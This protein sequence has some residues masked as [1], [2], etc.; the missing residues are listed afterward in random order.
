ML[1]IMAEFQKC[2]DVNFGLNYGQEDR[3]FI[4]AQVH[5]SLVVDTPIAYEQWTIDTLGAII[6]AQKLTAEGGEFVIPAE[7]KTGDTWGELKKIG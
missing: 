5:D 1:K 3:P 2:L 6:N 7:F 4:V